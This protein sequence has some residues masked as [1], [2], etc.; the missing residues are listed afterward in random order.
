MIRIEHLEIDDPVEHKILEDLH[1]D[2]KVVIL[3][4]QAHFDK[5][6]TAACLIKYDDF[7]DEKSDSEK[8]CSP[9]KI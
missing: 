7:R 3:S 1:N 4:E 9:F 5:T 6:G 8:D 2:K